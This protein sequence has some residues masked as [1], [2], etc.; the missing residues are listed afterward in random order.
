MSRSLGST[1]LTTFPSIATVP[2]VIVFQPGDHAQQGRF[3]AARRPD[4]DH[5]LAVGDG[6][7]DAVHD[8]AVAVGF[9]DVV[10]GQ[11]GHLACPYGSRRKCRSP[12][13]V[14]VSRKPN[15]RNLSRQSGAI[16]IADAGGDRHIALHYLAD[17]LV[18]HV[19]SGIAQVEELVFAPMPPDLG[20]VDQ[21]DAGDGLAVERDPR[22]A[23]GEDFAQRGIERLLLLQRLDRAAGSRRRPSAAA[24]GC[25][26]HRRSTA[27]RYG[28]ARSF[29][30]LD[31]AFDE[32]ALHQQHHQRPAARSPAARS[33]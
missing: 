6:A 30:A 14:S 31:Q 8:L 10:E 7:A 33:P 27:G 29:L 12:T 18:E 26:R 4:H 5:Q 17:E 13:R 22:L 25:R 9:L 1:A 28:R 3:P 16:G 24:H 20:A 23:E 32:P 15:L 2:E 19:A 11:R 21:G